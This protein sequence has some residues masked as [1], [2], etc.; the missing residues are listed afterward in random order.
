MFRRNA[1]TMGSITGRCSG[2]KTGLERAAEIE[3]T[4]SIEVSFIYKAIILSF[5]FL[6]KGTVWKISYEVVMS[7]SQL[8]SLLTSHFNSCFD[9]TDDSEMI[10]SHTAIIARVTWYC[11]TYPQPWCSVQ[12]LRVRIWDCYFYSV[13][14]TCDCP[15]VFLPFDTR[16]GISRRRTNQR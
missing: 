14:I 13:V 10:F 4:I 6:S 15:S 9:R 2:T 16:F 12:K 8:Q 3:P 11:I 5:F 1:I 7:K